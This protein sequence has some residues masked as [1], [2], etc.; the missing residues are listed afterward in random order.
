MKKLIETEK[1]FYKVMIEV[2]ALGYIL[3]RAHNEEKAVETG[4]RT[5][6]DYLIHLHDRFGNRIRLIDCELILGD[7]DY[8]GLEY[9]EGPNVKLLELN[10]DG[11]LIDPYI[12]A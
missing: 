1:K 4:D 6:S 9:E 5:M 2:K 11:E 12:V 8:I 10:N 7:Q 3:V